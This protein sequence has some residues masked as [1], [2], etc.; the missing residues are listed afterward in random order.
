MKSTTATLTKPRSVTI[1]AADRLFVIPA[2]DSGWSCWG[3]DTC[4]WEATQLAQLL[5]EPLPASAEIG[6]L[7]QYQYARRLQGLFARRPDLN[8]HTWFD[9]RTPIAVR[10][11]LEYCRT[12]HLRVRIFYGDTDTGR[13]WLDEWEMVGRIGRSTGYMRIPLLVPDR[14]HGGPGL[15]DSSIIRIINTRTHGNVY[16][17]PKFHLPPFEFIEGNVAPGHPEYRFGVNV[18]GTNHANFKTAEERDR[19]V[20]FMNGAR[21]TT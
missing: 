7:K 6:T 14:E 19:W 11:A 13:S 1:N 21:Y 5:Q 17:H 9:A 4:F 16:C 2:G 20:A 15:L 10:Q 12:Q 8:Q 18:N 3:F